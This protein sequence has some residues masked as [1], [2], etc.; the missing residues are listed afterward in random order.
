M[1]N[2]AQNI[3]VIGELYHFFDDGKTSSSRHYI[4]KVEEIIDIEKAKD[5]NVDYFLK[6]DEPWVNTLYDVWQR[7]V[8]E[9]QTYNKGLFLEKTD[10]V[11][12]CNIPN[13]DDN[14]IYF[15]RSKYGWFSLNINSGLQGGILDV[16]GNMFEGIISYYID[17]KYDVSHYYAAT[18]EK[19]D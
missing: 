12:K 9:C 19:K 2:N 10:K 15:V 11:I 13:Y 16:D 5:I 14:F 7:E 6:D 18:Y 4:A 17:N 1:E 3:P 8:K